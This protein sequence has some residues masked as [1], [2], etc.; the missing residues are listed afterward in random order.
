MSGR[1]L[2]LFGLCVNCRK[3]SASVRRAIRK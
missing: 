3:S 1:R 2:V